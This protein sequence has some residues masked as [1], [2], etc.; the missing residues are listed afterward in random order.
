MR[1]QSS[2]EMEIPHAPRH[3]VILRAGLLGDTLVAVPALWCLRQAYPD[4]RITY[5]W[6]DSPQKGHVKAYEVLGS[7]GLV[8]T[9]LSYK[10]GRST[11]SN[12][13]SAGALLCKLQ[14]QT[15]DLAVVL[16]EPHWSSRKT[17]FAKLF[18]AEAVIGPRGKGKHLP[19]MPNGNLLKLP[20]IADALIEQLRP[21]GIPLPLPGE[22][23]V[24][25]GLG[26][27]D[28][29][30]VEAWL[31]TA[32]ARNAP[33]PWIGLCPW[34]NMPAKRWPLERYEEVVR[35]LISEF[36]VTPFVLGGPGERDV[37]ELLVTQ[38]GRGYVACGEL[39]I[40]E[41]VALLSQCAL[42]VGNDTGV[43]HM[44]AAAGTRCVAM[45]SSRE[46]PGRWEPYGK[47]HAVFRSKVL[48]EGCMLYECLDQDM[49]C[50][51][52]IEVDEVLHACRSVLN[53]E[54]VEDSHF[55][56]RSLRRQTK[57][58]I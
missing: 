36:N 19:R 23:R 5:V 53:H 34:S 39:S 42:Y 47:G 18:G 24:D 45:F 9:F 31:A 27:R 35:A 21:L 52:L 22:G 37:A 43:M 7:S 6:Q 2:S 13:F 16:E 40:R 12:L 44:A 1:E 17:T 11:F 49:R 33:H 10:T 56:I 54:H 46:A 25:I 38:W 14:T 58:D 8:D 48:C 29:A 15:C 26:D 30:R 51:R 28:C 50:M 41:G 20:H 57:G 32:G 55:A 4:A 3:I